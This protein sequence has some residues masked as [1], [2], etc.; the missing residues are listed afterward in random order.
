MTVNATKSDGTDK[1]FDAMMRQIAILVVLSCAFVVAL[2]MPAQADADRFTKNMAVGERTDLRV[3]I[4]AGE[5]DPETFIPVSVIKGAL[6]GPTVLMVAGVHGYEFSPILAAQRLADEIDPEKLSGEL[7]IVRVAHVAAFEGRSPYVN[8]NDRKNLNRSFPGKADGTQTERI[9]WAL[10][11]KIIPA[12]DFVLDVHSGDGAEWLDAFVG[13][14]GGPLSSDYQSA[15]QFAE[16]MGFPNIVRYSMNT[17][18]QVDRRRSLN[19]QAVAQGLPTILVEIGQNGSRKPDHVE[20]IVSGVKRGLSTLGMLEPSGIAAEK[21][22]RYF[23]GTQSVPVS[24]SGIWT[25][26]VAKGR[27]LESGEILGT[28]RDYDGR[29]VETVTASVSGFTIYGLA[30]P[31]VRAGESIATIAKPSSREILSRSAD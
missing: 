8:P 26:N 15:F 19:R 21:P 4:P 31:P 11:S 10:S 29:L 3:E 22:L 30:G 28:I 24:H 17:Q 2:S 23:E 18:E 16:A 6:P 12:A 7:I 13:V 25:P 9:A 5:T 20:A 27:Y 14:Y 1:G